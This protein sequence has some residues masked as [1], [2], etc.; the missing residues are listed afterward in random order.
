MNYFLAALALIVFVVLPAAILCRNWRAR[1]RAHYWH[2]T[3]SFHR[4][5]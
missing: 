1:R 3:R 4:P 2:Q 5:K